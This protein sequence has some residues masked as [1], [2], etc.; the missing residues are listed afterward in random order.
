MERCEEKQPP[1]EHDMGAVERPEWKNKEPPGEQWEAG[2]LERPPCKADGPL[3]QHAQGKEKRHAEHG[4][5]HDL[6]AEAVYGIVGLVFQ[7]GDGGAC[8][9][10]AAKQH[11]RKPSEGGD[12][13][14]ANLRQRRGETGR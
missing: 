8:A 9:C 14:G 13:P 1:D 4:G 3:T 5:H 7:G 6:H 11:P 10:E 2:D 12:E